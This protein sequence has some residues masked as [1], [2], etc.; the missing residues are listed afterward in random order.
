MKYNDYRYNDKYVVPHNFLA[1]QGV[2]SVILNYPYTFERVALALSKDSF[3]VK[4]HQVLYE[5]FLSLEKQKKEINLTTLITYLQDNHY[6]SE[7]GGLSNIMNI[8]K[9]FQPIT[10]LSEHIKALN[11]KTLRRKLIYLGENLI[12]WGYLTS[13]PL[14][15]I[16]EELERNVFDLSQQKI[17]E[18]TPTSAEILLDTLKE[19]QKK[20]QKKEK[21]GYETSFTDL[22]TIIQGFQKTDV[23]VIAGRPS[24]GKT[25]LG[26]NIARNIVQNYNVPIIFFSLEMSRQQLMY[27][28]LSLDACVSGSRLKSGQITKNEWQ[29]LKNASNR[30][31]SYPI[32]IDDNPRI[33]LLEIK[34]KIRR[35]RIMHKQVGLVI[36]DY[37]QLMK[38]TMKLQN[39]AQEISVITRNL[40]TIA[41]EYDVPLI[42]LSQLSRGVESRLNKRP[43]LSDLRES[44]CIAKKKLQ[45]NKSWDGEKI[46][47]VNK[48][49]LLLKG[50]KPVYTFNNKFSLSA[51]HKILSSKGWLK[52]SEVRSKNIKLIINQ[53]TFQQKI[54][55]FGL[56]YNHSQN[57][58]DLTIPIFHNFLQH[59]IILH[60]SIEQDADVVLMLYRDDYYK[61][62]NP[63]N[64]TRSLIDIIVAKH[65]NGPVGNASLI[66]D[67]NIMRF[68]NLEE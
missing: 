17:V 47:N 43:I 11:D 67:T 22:D 58:F 40:K 65:R 59:K 48:K 3:Y 55:S 6:L 5:A 28:L 42:V 16:L 29:R 15:E 9:N 51:N 23:I 45:T 13:Y 52:I 35:I 19:L 62:A 21:S 38:L 57:V 33:N 37:L 25:A 50:K 18:S 63:K 32:Y 24:M 7:A 68:F 8:F 14:D 20:N 49:D 53:I 61:A 34:A 30:L 31:S 44:G 60:N 12:E 46:L 66:F 2:L 41:K 54:K 64:V 39:R 56:N 26:L 36:I 10:S 4:E 1:E 27:R